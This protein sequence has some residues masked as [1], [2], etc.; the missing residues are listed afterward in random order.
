M[1]YLISVAYDGSKFFGFQRL[2]DHE[3]VQRKLEEALKI[4]AKKEVETKGAGRT[5]KGVH[6]LDQKVTFNL[7]INIDCNHLTLALN[8]LLSPYIYITNT[9]VV[10]DDFHPRFH[11]SKKEY[12][13]KIIT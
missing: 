2:K 8:S 4:I 13:Y 5:D 6:A 9:E 3:T 10:D 7:D 12:I 11:V 1:K